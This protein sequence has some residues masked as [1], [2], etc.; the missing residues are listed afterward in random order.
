VAEEVL[1]RGNKASI[2]IDRYAGCGIRDGQGC[3]GSDGDN[4]VSRQDS[5]GGSG[6]GV[7]PSTCEDV[8]AAAQAGGGGNGFAVS[9]N[10]AIFA[11]EG[12]GFAWAGKQQVLPQFKKS[13]GCSE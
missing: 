1:A 2:A 12:S 9:R 3:V 8:P 5:F 10:L 13:K 6:G 7:R 4:L 11:G